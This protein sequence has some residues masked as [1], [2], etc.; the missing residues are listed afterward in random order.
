M[1]AFGGAWGAGPFEKKQNFGFSI[2]RGRESQSLSSCS[3]QEH[4][5]PAPPPPLPHR[6]WSQ[7]SAR[8]FAKASLLPLG[9]CKELRRLARRSTQKH[10]GAAPGGAPSFFFF[11][12]KIQL[13]NL[14]SLFFFYFNYRRRNLNTNQPIMP[15]TTSTVGEYR[16]KERE[17]RIGTQNENEREARLESPALDCS[18]SPLARG[19]RLGPP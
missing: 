15:V 13:E 8:A 10:G 1:A 2:G 19:D 11:S 9:A 5:P 12:L 14:L 18:F 3:R 17:R 4:R 6:P 16:W 7:H